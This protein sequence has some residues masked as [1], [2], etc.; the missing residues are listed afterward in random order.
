MHV[1]KNSRRGTSKKILVGGDLKASDMIWTG[2]SEKYM[3]ILQTINYK[4]RL[5]PHKRVQIKHF[6]VPTYN[7]LSNINKVV[8]NPDETVSKIFFFNN[9]F[10]FTIL[11]YLFI[12]FFRKHIFECFYD[13]TIKKAIEIQDYYNYRL[14]LKCI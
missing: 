2:V 10:T 5:M 1:N 11:K 12:L 3:V 4:K 14:L 8:H 9:F 6:F 13:M 7:I